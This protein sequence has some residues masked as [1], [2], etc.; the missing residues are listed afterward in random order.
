MTS[1]QFRTLPEIL[2]S[3]LLTGRL[4][5]SECNGSNVF[6]DRYDGV[7]MILGYGDKR[8]VGRNNLL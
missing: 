6:E 5:I 2:E 7:K 3:L 4:L 1:I 8:G